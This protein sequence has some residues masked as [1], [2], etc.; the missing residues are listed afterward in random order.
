MISL[1]SNED[2]IQVL[3]FVCES[4]IADTYTRAPPGVRLNARAVRVMKQDKSTASHA[5]AP[6][7]H[8][9]AAC[10]QM[11]SFKLNE[12]IP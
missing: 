8:D 6:A 10:H 9:P 2:Y 4:T 3:H 12:A 11:Y 7:T 1:L 5:P